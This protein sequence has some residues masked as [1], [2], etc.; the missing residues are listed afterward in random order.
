MLTSL[1][2]FLRTFRIQQGELL[3]DMADK[4]NVAP[5]YLSSIENGKRSATKKLINNI[6]DSYKLTE[7]QLLELNAAFFETLDEVNL[8]T[9]NATATQRDLCISFARKFNNL[10]NAQI[11]EIKKILEVSNK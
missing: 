11:E 4:L 2:K 5:A 8:C 7:A 6:A 10:N 3:K 9:K 1:G